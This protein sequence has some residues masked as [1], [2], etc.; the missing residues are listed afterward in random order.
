MCRISFKSECIKCLMFY[1]NKAN[2]YRVD[3]TKVL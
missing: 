3:Q 2:E 1:K